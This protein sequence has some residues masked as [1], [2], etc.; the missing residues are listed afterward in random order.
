MKLP[1]RYR[2]VVFLISL[3]IVL[4]WFTWRFVLAETFSTWLECRR[5]TRELNEQKPVEA[6]V[7]PSA[8]EELLFSGR[9]LDTLQRAAEG[10]RVRVTGYLPLVTQRQDRLEIHTAQVILT[11]KY[12]ELLPV[13]RWAEVAL[14]C[15]RMRSLC[16]TATEDPGSKRKMLSATFYMEQIIVKKQQYEN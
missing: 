9:L 13:I 4:P 2:G 6:V 15:C 7:V 11:G 8:R 5:L 12:T 14:P 10:S 3:L 16:W 1:F